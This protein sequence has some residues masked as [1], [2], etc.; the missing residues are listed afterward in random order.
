MNNQDKRIQ[1]VSETAQLRTELVLG[2]VAPL[3]TNLDTVQ[4]ELEKALTSAGY[5]V[6]TI[7]VASDIIPLI[8]PFL[9]E[10]LSPFELASMKMNKGNDAR[11]K[12][13]DNAILAKGAAAKIAENRNDDENKVKEPRLRSATI[14]RSLKHREEVELLRLIYP[15]GFYLIGVNAEKERRVK[16]LEKD[17]GIGESKAKE[18]IER[19]QNEDDKRGQQVAKTFHMSDFFV[20]IDGNSDRLDSSLGRIV[21]LILGNP[22]L[23]PTFDEFA[24]FSAFAASLRSADLSRQVGA[25]V[26]DDANCEVLGSGAN[27]CPRFHGGLYW[28]IEMGSQ[29]VDVKDGRDVAKGFDT[30]E[31][32]RDRIAAQ[33]VSI[34]SNLGCDKEKLKQQ[35]E[36]SLIQDITEYS[37][38]VH[39]EMESLLFC[40]R[41][42]IPTRGKSLFTTTFPCHNC[43]K[44]IVAAGINRVIYVEPYPKSR[45]AEFHSDSLYVADSEGDIEKNKVRFEAFEGVGPRRFFDLFSMNLGSGKSIKRKDDDGNVM[46]WKRD[47]AIPRRQMFPFSYLDLEAIAA[48]EFTKFQ[49][50]PEELKDEGEQRN[51]RGSN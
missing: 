9:P 41:V 22:H 26:A 24:M 15:Q 46:L 19:D 13:K 45:A 39:A 7:R 30:N 37:R 23:T 34:A 36:S 49:Q 29:I 2:L 31:K 12:A 47:E 4:A 42:G 51:R 5:E 48:N 6:A 1:N 11:S 10:K 27:D 43:A 38:A 44:H 28:P 40:G 18:L 35:L 21:E 33:V 17:R 20:R 3:G 50:L 25:V 32:E 16:F 8:E 14:I